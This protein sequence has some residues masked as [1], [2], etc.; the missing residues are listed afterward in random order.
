MV[1]ER[2][3]IDSFS[4]GSSQ[5]FLQTFLK[6]LYEVTSQYYDYDI[7]NNAIK[8]LLSTHFSIERDR[9]KFKKALKQRFYE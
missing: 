5:F 1:S 4:D 3:H 2:T 8:E 9:F 7:E 6:Y